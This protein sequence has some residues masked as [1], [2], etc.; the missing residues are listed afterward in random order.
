MEGRLEV[1]FFNQWGSICGDSWGQNEA[2]VICNQLGYS[3][4]GRMFS[5]SRQSKL[6]C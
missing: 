2:G 1:C 5:K 4:T 3:R 6:H